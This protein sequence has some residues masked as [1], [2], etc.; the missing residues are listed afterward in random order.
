[1]K[2]EKRDK[3]F[4]TWLCSFHRKNESCTDENLLLLDILTTFR[5][6]NLNFEKLMGTQ[7]F[8]QELFQN[9]S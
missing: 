9:L 7:K 6:E 5:E 4:D 1:M 2:V 8:V 3:L